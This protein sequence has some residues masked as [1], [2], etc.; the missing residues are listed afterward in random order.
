MDLIHA[1]A[2]EKLQCTHYD[3]NQDQQSVTWNSFLDITALLL[4]ITILFG[5][6]FCGYAC[7]FGSLGDALYE[8]TAFI[9]AKCF[10]KKGGCCY[11]KYKLYGGTDQP[12][13]SLF[14]F[15]AF[16]AFD[17][18][19]FTASKIPVELK[20]APEMVERTLFR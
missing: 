4:I 19:S 12:Y 13:L 3:H 20:V 2:E 6:H 15:H 17:N 5:R 10:G 8:L 18:A 11:K 7:A 9:R 14:L 1:N 16:S